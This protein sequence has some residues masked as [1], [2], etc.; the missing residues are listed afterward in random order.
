MKDTTPRD[1]PQ[2]G[3]MITY[4]ANVSTEDLVLGNRL[5]TVTTVEGPKSLVVGTTQLFENGR[6][7]YIPMP[8]PDPKG[9]DNRPVC[10]G[11]LR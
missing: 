2:A 3:A 11:G 10:H 9:E 6:I 4:K 1:Q 7:R 5:G 8:T